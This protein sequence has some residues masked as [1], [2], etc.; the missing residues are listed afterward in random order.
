[1]ICV[2]NYVRRGP[3]L[4]HF[5]RLHV[6]RRLSRPEPNVVLGLFM[7]LFRPEIL[8]RLLDR[9]GN[10]SLDP[11]RFSF[12]MDHERNPCLGNPVFAGDVS[13]RDAVENHLGFNFSIHKNPYWIPLSSAGGRKIGSSKTILSSYEFHQSVF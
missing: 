11:A 6:L 9:S 7:I 4:R 12:F 8:D 3:F 5:F 2:N 1:M 13:I 10:G